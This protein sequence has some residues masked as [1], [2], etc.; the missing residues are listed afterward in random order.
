MAPG[1]VWRRDRSLAIEGHRIVEVGPRSPAAGSRRAHAA[2]LGRI[3]PGYVADLRAVD[4]NPA[5]DLDA[6]AWVRL[7]IARGRIVVERLK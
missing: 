4:G 3:A 7:A 2:A 6:P 1:P 5:D